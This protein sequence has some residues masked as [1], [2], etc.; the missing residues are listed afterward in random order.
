MQSSYAG[1]MEKERKRHEQQIRSDIDDEYFAII[2]DE[3]GDFV[4]KVYNSIREFGYNLKT[5]PIVTGIV[6]VKERGLL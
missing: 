2:K 3:I 4:E 1:N 6:I 5:T